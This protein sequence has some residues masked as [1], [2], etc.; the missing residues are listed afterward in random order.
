MHAEVILHGD[1]FDE[2]AIRELLN[3]LEYEKI[4][5]EPAA[6]CVLAAL[7]AGKIPIKPKEIVVVIL[8]GANISHARVC[9]WSEK[10]NKPSLRG[11]K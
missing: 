1:V 3:I 10:Y 5:V 6:S 2:E 9:E 11:T 4:M 7:V 8:C